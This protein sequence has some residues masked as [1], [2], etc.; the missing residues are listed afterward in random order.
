MMVGVLGRCLCP[1]RWRF[2]MKVT[3]TGIWAGLCWKGE[4]S[5]MVLETEYLSKSGYPVSGDVR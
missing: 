2:L 1:L 5:L 4:V 3:G